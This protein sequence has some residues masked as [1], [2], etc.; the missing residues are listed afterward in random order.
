MLLTCPLLLE[1]LEIIDCEKL[2]II[3]TYDTNEEV[4]HGDNDNKN[5]SSMF[6]RLNDH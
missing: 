5:C 6:P 4:V 2:E 3:I 1:S